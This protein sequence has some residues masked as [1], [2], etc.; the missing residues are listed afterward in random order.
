MLSTLLTPVVLQDELFKQFQ[1][2]LELGFADLAGLASL[3]L[4]TLS[5][6]AGPF[7]MVGG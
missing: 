2:V 7:R 4:L 3:E 5:V 1:G 6:S